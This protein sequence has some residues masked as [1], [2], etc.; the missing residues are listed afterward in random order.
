M[1]IWVLGAGGM[2]GRAL[3]RYLSAQQASFFGTLRE[4]VDITSYEQLQKMWEKEQPTHII[5]CAAYTAVDLAEKEQERAYAVNAEGPKYLGMLASQYGCRVI[6]ISTD[7]VFEGTKKDPY[8]ETDETAPL[9]IYGKSKREGE[10]NLLSACPKACIVR[11]SWLFGEGGK[12]FISTLLKLFQEQEEVRV[13]SDQYSRA[14]Y[15][16]D[17]CAAL[18]ALLNEEGIFH[19]ANAGVVSRFDIAQELYTLIPEMQRRCRRLIPV[20]HTAFPLPAQRPLCSVLSTKKIE[21]A[22]S[23]SIR[24]WKEILEEFVCSAVCL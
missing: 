1:K 18:Y 9:S 21:A 2:L 3:Q 24:S 8:L 16:P 15:A 11:T 10:K 7:Y 23:I 13:V 17:M 6:H 22:L 5:N 19:F 20:S 14:T 4:S 12:N